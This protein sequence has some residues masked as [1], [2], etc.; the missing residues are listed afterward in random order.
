MKSLIICF[1]FIWGIYPLAAQKQSDSAVLSSGTRGKKGYSESQDAYSHSGMTIASMDKTARIRFVLRQQLEAWNAGNMEGYMQGYW[2][3]DSLQFIT[4]KK[5]TY[6]YQTVLENYK[7][8]YPNK[9]KMGH[10][11]F[12]ILKIQFLDPLSNTA[13]VLG[14]W[15]VQGENSNAQG[16]FSLIL[17]FFGAEP[18][19]II[20]HT[21]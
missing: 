11:D 9:E 16:T 21:F 1:I 15:H 7:K 6:G 20:D 18:K 14:T 17:K 8:S 3:S 2:N 19:I 13:Q 10:L 5:I 12:E 4:A